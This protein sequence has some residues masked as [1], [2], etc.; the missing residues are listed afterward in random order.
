LLTK[1][2]ID[3]IIDLLQLHVAVSADENTLLIVRLGLTYTNSVTPKIFTNANKYN[4]SK[5]TKF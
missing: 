1:L 3:K 4:I 2:Y 5:Q